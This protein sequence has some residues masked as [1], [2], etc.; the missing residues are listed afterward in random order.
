M[1]IT[2]SSFIPV[3]LLTGFVWPLEGIQQTWLR[4]KNHFLFGLL[5]VW[6][7][8][9]EIETRIVLRLIRY[10]TWDG[11]SDFWPW[12][13]RHQRWVIYKHNLY[14]RNSVWYLPQTAAIQVIWW[15][16]YLCTPR[17]AIHIG[18]VCAISAYVGGVWAVRLFSRSYL[19][20]DVSFHS[21]TRL[22][23]CILKL[24][25]GPS[26]LLELGSRLSSFKLVAC[27]QEDI[28]TEE[29]LQNDSTN[30]IKTL[31]GIMAVLHL[32]ENSFCLK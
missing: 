1:R 17:Y 26:P 7:F 31:N 10:L 27:Q 2:C 16:Q 23:T 24:T 21:L 6:L 9:V 32:V 13:R 28:N 18:R 29:S 22:I 15:W 19:K 20:L 12:L 14:T 11:D 30:V 8:V 3:L 4:W 5:D 25:P